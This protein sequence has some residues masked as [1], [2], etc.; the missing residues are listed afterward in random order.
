[1]A[2]LGLK[3]SSDFRELW[4]DPEEDIPG[5]GLEICLSALEKIMQCLWL[6]LLEVC[7]HLFGT[8]SEVL[9]LDEE[10][11]HSVIGPGCFGKVYPTLKILPIGVMN[12][13]KL[14]PGSGLE[15]RNLL[16]NPSAVSWYLFK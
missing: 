15:V 14:S 13:D 4:M 6:T 3:G 9:F 10:F 7:C 11:L 1:M 16:R 2:S 5:V 12:W 8:G